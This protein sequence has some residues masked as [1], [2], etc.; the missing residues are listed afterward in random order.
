MTTI[1]RVDGISKSFDGLK[2]LSNVS[3]DVEEG[4]IFGLM[5]ANGA[6]K[7]TLF[8]IIAGQ[9]RPSGGTVSFRNQI[10][11]GRRP[12][13]ISRMGIYRTFQIVRPFAGITLP[14]NPAVPAL[15][16]PP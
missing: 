5:G 8:A 1:L 6:G 7:T 4:S 13:H 16:L 14:A 2:A 12:D 9:V 3:F 10:L 15:P 11:T